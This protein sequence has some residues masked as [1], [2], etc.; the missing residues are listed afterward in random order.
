MLT[1]TH[2]EGPDRCPICRS[3]NTVE[4]YPANI[5]PKK[6]TFSYN[7]TPQANKTFRVVRCCRCT[8]VFCSPI[9]KNIFK[10]Y[11][12]VVDKS[13]LRYSSTRQLNAKHVLK[14]IQSYIPTGLLLDVGCATGDFLTVAKNSGYSAEGLEL[15]KWSSEITKKKGIPV[16]TE[17]LKQLANRFSGRYDIVTMW[18][19][20]EHFE[21]PL[22]EMIYIK[23]LLNPNGIIALWTGDVDSV[24]SRLLGRRWW[25]WQGQHVQYFTN[26]SLDY[27]AKLCGF[28][29]I[30][31]KIYP[32][33]TTYELLKEALNR[34]RLPQWIVKM[35]RPFFAIKPLWTLRLP[36]EMFWIARNKTRI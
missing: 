5:D 21:H 10:N 12:N 13:Y 34:Y 35:P 24:T 31:T 9:P 17:S 29:H 3:Q 8:H 1:S 4:W 22:E 26:S 11:E 25:Y 19:V 7:K 23:K 30:V 14:I 2:P 28:E 15:S 16:Y 27:L 36:G 20:I 33:L 6:L 18:G 32:F